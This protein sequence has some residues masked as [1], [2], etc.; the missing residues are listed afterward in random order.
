MT[1][2]PKS[3]K[4]VR[5]K[6]MRVELS[7]DYGTLKLK[8]VMKTRKRHSQSI[9]LMTFPATSWSISLQ[10][11]FR[12]SSKELRKGKDLESNVSE[13]GRRSGHPLHVNVR[14]LLHVIKGLS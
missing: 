5:L 12:V 2:M 8:L 11:V 13:A 3:Q 10:E 7:L 4:Y 14:L 1:L 6:C 9:L